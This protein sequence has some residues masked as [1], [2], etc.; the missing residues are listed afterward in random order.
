M[1][2]TR[3]KKI[4]STQQEIWRKIEKDELKEDILIIADMQTN[5]V[6]NTWKKMVYVRGEYSFF[7]CNK[8]KL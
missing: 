3:Y 2:I 8:T 1:Q 5:G 7:I 4:D 6:R